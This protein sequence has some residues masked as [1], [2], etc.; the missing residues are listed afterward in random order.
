M[1]LIYH[2]STASI[3]FFFKWSIKVQQG[4]PFKKWEKRKEKKR[5]RGLTF[6]LFAV[7]PLS[8][9]LICTELRVSRWTHSLKLFVAFC[10]MEGPWAFLFSFSL[11]F[12]LLRFN[13]YVSCIFFVTEF[14]LSDPHKSS[15]TFV[16]YS[17]LA[18]LFF[19]FFFK[20]L[21]FGF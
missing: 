4:Y 19:F 20:L 21:I 10:L 15:G 6:A 17:A 3:L 5:K 7:L 13:L 1:R 11:S 12:L 18:L 8:V 14:Q 16:G 9:F 2:K